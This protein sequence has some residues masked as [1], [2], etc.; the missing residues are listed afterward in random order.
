MTSPSPFVRI[1]VLSF[2][3]G[4]MTIDCIDS[5]LLTA[6]PADG[7]E[8][9]MVDN[10][11]LD[12]VTARVRRDYPMVRVLEPLRPPPTIRKDTNCART[13]SRP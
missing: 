6:W 11:S 12:D 10:G 3:G 5:L 9:V 8:I 2:D 1:V 7:Y 13:S 4:Q